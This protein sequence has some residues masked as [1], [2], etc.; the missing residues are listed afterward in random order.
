[1]NPSWGRSYA[2]VVAQKKVERAPKKVEKSRFEPLGEIN[3]KCSGLRPGTN[4]AKVKSIREIQKYGKKETGKVK[5]IEKTKV[6][7]DYLNAICNYIREKEV[8]HN[9]ITQVEKV[10]ETLTY[11]DTEAKMIGECMV[12]YVSCNT[13]MLLLNKRL[14]KFPVKGVSAI[15]EELKQMHDCTCFK[16]IVVAE[17]SQRERQCTMQAIMFL[18][19]NKSKE[20]KG[21]LE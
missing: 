18:T 11:N 6:D 1:M 16:A 12:H 7:A 5:E 15:K 9:L 4:M 20:I 13:Q 2:Q 10:N 8:E 14:K 3:S 17:L 21:R 19:E